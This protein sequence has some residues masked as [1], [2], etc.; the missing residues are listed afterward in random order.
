MKMARLGVLFDR[1]AAERRWHYGL[2]AFDRYVGE[3]LNDAG[4]PF[5]WLEDVEQLKQRPY[6]IVIAALTEE[7]EHTVSVL[8]DYAEQGGS[9]IS[10]GGVNALASKLGYASASPVGAGYAMWGEHYSKA[11]AV[12]FLRAQPWREDKEPAACSEFGT[13]AVSQPNG[14]SAGAARHSF[15]I[16][17][18]S[19][20]RFAVDVID[21]I[22]RLQ[23]GG[24]PVLEDG[25]PAPDGSAPLNDGILKADDQT[26]MDWEW[27]R[28]TTETGVPYFAYP[29]ADYWREI[30]IGHLLRLAAGKGLTLPF[31]GCW[32]EGVDRVAMISH[33]S[34]GNKDEYAQATLELMKEVGVQSS[35]CMLEPGYSKPVYEQIKSDGHELAFHYNAL[36][37]QKGRWG[38]EE[39]ARQFAWLTEAA[40]LT[41]VA[42]NKNHYTRFEGWGELFAFCEAHGIQSDQTR[43]PSKK[44]NV[45]FLFG[46]CHP[47]VPIAWSNDRNR[48]Y[49]VLEI[50][51]LTQDLDLS[52]HW[53]DS[54][55]I[56]P[57]LNGVAGVNGV[58]HFLFHQIHIYKQ[59]SVR[60]AL[61]R[62]VSEARKHGFVFWTGK[63]I[64]DWQRARRKLN[65][66]G[67]DDQGAVQ[68][69]GQSIPAG[70][71]AW[72]P[73]PH[74]TA[75]KEEGTELHFGVVCVKRPLR[76]EAGSIERE[77]D[78]HVQ[79]GH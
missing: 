49:D 20:D 27:D 56:A 29:Y 16:G 74:G 33:D 54:S 73:V 78:L 32:P 46:T 47:Y 71:V 64:N 76:S 72:V 6:D 67:L 62:V 38:A 30:V 61:R 75:E 13:I 10:Y 26:A 65:I 66:T 59:E 44:G 39:F 53:A 55:V 4:I 2:N 35:W 5:E 79:T 31:I 11:E 69:A 52:D 70:A 42:S 25:A 43:G 18:G 19:L 9:L 34:D 45:G 15:R 8:W 23:Q 24:M 77:D 17:A 14:V 28:K 51:F 60:N 36:E 50:G 3:L 41:E 40:E 22:V 58:A 48:S 1:K 57:F 68:V 63:Q 37:S 7:S 12:R 21:T